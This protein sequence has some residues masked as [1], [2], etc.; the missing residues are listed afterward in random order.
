MTSTGFQNAL[1]S[2]FS[3]Q[4][5]DLPWRRTY[6]PYHIWISEIML[7]QTQMERVVT[8]FKRWME[9][10]P[11]I[12]SL[13]EASE[14]EALTLWEGLGYYSRARNILQSAALI[15]A[16]HQ[17]A[18]P[19]DH[20]A[21]LALPG[22]GR[23]TAGAIMSLAFN[24]PYP[25]VDANVERVFARLFNIEVPVK[26]K[27]A[28]R[29]IWQKAAELI[30]EGEARFFNQA[31]MELGALICTPQSPRCSDCPITDYCAALSLDMVDL[32][33]V[34]GRSKEVI[35]IDM[36]TGVL[37][38][39][40]LFYI[41]KRL[42]NDVWPN[43]WEFPGGRMKTGETPEE[44]LIREYMEETEFS[45]HNL[46]KITTIKHSYTKYRVTLHCYSCALANGSATPTLHAAQEFRW[47]A[48]QDF[49]SFAFPAPHRRLI[50]RIV[51]ELI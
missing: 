38:H 8:Y 50:K 15:K 40:G 9:R 5:R 42:A 34:P 21:L 45:I 35:P 11:D 1:L 24:Q 19:A 30:P 10:Y 37:A 26:E 47:I 12:N 48:L 7:Q 28:H 33:P 14:Q 36:V 18:L 4:S 49:E 13:A 2:W 25:V 3:K 41:Q 39:D 6:L 43:L 29:F 16:R 20:A 32:R 46:K 51:Q 23:Y 22:I 44:A 31:L 17:G 27:T